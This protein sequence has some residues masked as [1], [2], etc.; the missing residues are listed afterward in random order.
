[1]MF[2]YFYSFII[3]LI[4]IVLA[5]DGFALSGA[6]IIGMLWN[7]IFTTAVPYTAWALA[8][9]K[10]DTARISNLAYITPFLSLVWTALFLKE[11]I[12]ANSFLGLV[13]IIAGIFIQL[14]DKAAVPA[15][16]QK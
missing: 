5:K 14:G 1:M 12:T 7:G 9:D 16:N 3:S 4:Y 15:E 13:I 10:G 6:Q 8:L 11:P 2:Y